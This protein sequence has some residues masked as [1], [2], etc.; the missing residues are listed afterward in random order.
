MASVQLTTFAKAFYSTRLIHDYLKTGNLKVAHSL[1]EFM[2]YRDKDI[3]LYGLMLNAFIKNRDYDECFALL[4]EMRQRQMPLNEVMYLQSI[5]LCIHSDNAD[6]ARSVHAEILRK[7]SIYRNIKIQN[8][9]IGL[10]TEFDPPTALEIYRNLSNLNLKP[11]AVTFLCVTKLVG[12]TVDIDLGMDIHA[13][14]RRND[15]FNRDI[16]LQ[17][18]LISMYGKCDAFHL[19]MSVFDDIKSGDIPHCKADEITYLNMIKCCASHKRLTEGESLHR[20][21]HRQKYSV[22]LQNALIDMYCHCGQYPS[23]MEVF[24]GMQRKDTLT[25]CLILKVCGKSKDSENGRR[26]HKEIDDVFLRQNSDRN[27]IWIHNAL[28][29]MYGQL[30]DIK[31]F[32]RIWRFM[33]DS[34]KYRS[35]VDIVSYGAM[36]NAYVQNAHSKY[37]NER[38]LELFDLAMDHGLCHNDKTIV[39][40][41][42]ACC[43]LGDIDR[44]QLIYQR[45]ESRHKENNMFIQNALKSL[46]E[47]RRV[48]TSESE[49]VVVRKSRFCAL[50]EKLNV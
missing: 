24:H 9:L 12:V 33:N 47:S 39:I 13:E 42:V 35:E 17:N 31:Q 4:D 5:K 27:S 29:N 25:Y 2:K 26:I 40:A 45:Y 20:D 21:I 50:S 19:A 1:W 11:N 6:A 37:C 34:P 7:E 3:K 18:A 48:N 14:I 8:A 10:Y 38:A 46:R 22:K 28:L 15:E 16:K 44:G 36:M 23:A 41:L 30:G 32:E 43:K 49:V